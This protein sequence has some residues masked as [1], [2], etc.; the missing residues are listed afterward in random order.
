MASGIDVGSSQHTSP[1]CGNLTLFHVSFHHLLNSLRTS[2]PEEMD[3]AEPHA[4][5]HAKTK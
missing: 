5:T 1:R 3:M 4:H 2:T